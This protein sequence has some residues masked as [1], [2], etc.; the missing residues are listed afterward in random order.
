MSTTL[1][2]KWFVWKSHCKAQVKFKHPGAVSTTLEAFEAN[3]LLD[4]VPVK[5]EADPKDRRIINIDNLKPHT[6]EIYITEALKDYGAIESV[7]ILKTPLKETMGDEE[8][9]GHLLKVGANQDERV[10]YRVLAKEKKECG[11]RV[12][13]VAIEDRHLINIICERLNKTIGM[14]GA[15]RLYV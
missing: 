13:Q 10:K 5:V 6:D 1:L 15:G 2:F 12:A 8:H 4:G 11:L 3:P 9:I 7:E 14:F